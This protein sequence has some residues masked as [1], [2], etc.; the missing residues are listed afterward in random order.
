MKMWA[1]AGTKTILDGVKKPGWIKMMKECHMNGFLVTSFDVTNAIPIDDVVKVKHILDE[2]GFDMIGIGLPL[3]HPEGLDTPC[4]TFHEGWHIRRDIEG[5]LVR[6]CNAITPKLIS[7]TKSHMEELRDIGIKA[8]FWDD[9]LR[10]GNYEGDVQGCFCDECLSEFS[11][12]YK[13][14]LS[15]PVSRAALKKVV[16][17][18]PDGLDEKAW[19]LREAWMKF[20]CDRVTRFMKETT[21]DG[22][23]N[24]IM[25]MHR[26][27][28]RHGIDIADIR[29]AVPDCLFRVGELMFDDKS[30]EAPGNKRALVESVLRH[31]EQMGEVSRIYSESTVYPHGAL[32][33]ENLRQKI[34][35]ERK[36]GIENINL[37]GVERMN[38]E[39]YYTM[40]RDN[41]QQFA[42]IEKEFT[43]ETLDRVE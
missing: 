4:Y 42:E 25:V 26:G 5:N 2:E 1:C 15:G 38:N 34:V 7:D 23:Q 3:G 41:Y 6:W 43:L 13:A 8:M 11:E 20:N 27:D 36:C 18:V 10:Q 9:D 35:L 14:I 28:R 33:P 22:M 21:V 30:F 31:M 16:A 19:A 39:A 24:G 12:T 40:L 32:T 37:M 17:K 29:S